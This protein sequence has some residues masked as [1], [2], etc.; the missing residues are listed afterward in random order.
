MLGTTSKLTISSSLTKLFYAALIQRQKKAAFAGSSIATLH[1]R[2]FD[3]RARETSFL[4]TPEADP[5][6]RVP[7]GWRAYRVDCGDLGG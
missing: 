3:G 4:K 7:K 1:S 5:Y 6:G 2:F